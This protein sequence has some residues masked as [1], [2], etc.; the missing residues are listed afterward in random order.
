LLGTHRIEI[1]IA[2]AVGQNVTTLTTSRHYATVE[3]LDR[4]IV[5]ARFWAGLHFRDSGEVESSSVGTWPIGRSTG[6][7]CRR[8]DLREIPSEGAR[9][10]APSQIPYEVSYVPTWVRVG[11]GATLVG[12]VAEL[13][14]ATG[15]LALCGSRRRQCGPLGDAVYGRRTFS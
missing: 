5:N 14:A 12:G 7:S 8:T 15:G 6:T 11:S 3:D 9:L 2:G 13:V 10:S 4:Q 1:N